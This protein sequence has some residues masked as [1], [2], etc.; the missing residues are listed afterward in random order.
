MATF[1]AIVKAVRADGFYTVYIRVTHHRKHGYIKTDKMVTKRELTKDN[2]IKDPYVLQYCTKRI[3]EYNERLNKKDI[4]Y[5]TA[6]EVVDFLVNGNDDICFSDYARIHINKMIDQGQERNARNY[7]LALQ[8]LER[9]A[10]TTKVMFSHLTS[11]FVN[12]WIKS[13][14]HTHRA[15]EIYPI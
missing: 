5:W 7:K 13:L 3:L 9:F 1:K 6:K 4:G 11:P 14:E 12:K 2:E 10:G 15:K 8:H